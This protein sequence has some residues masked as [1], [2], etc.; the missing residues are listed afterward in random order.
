MKILIADD[1]IMA[2]KMLIK[3]IKEIVTIP[4][5]IIQASNGSEAIKSFEREEPNIVF[6]GL[7]IPQIDGIEV[8]KK[9]KKMN[10]KANIITLSKDMEKD[11]IEKI[12][13]LD[14]L[15][16]IK[17]PVSNDIISKYFKKLGI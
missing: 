1:S 16:Y 12:N 15:G 9:I 6:I 7:K 13:S 3:A 14:I 4:I 11:T 8:I 2:R 5:K 17:K 10:T